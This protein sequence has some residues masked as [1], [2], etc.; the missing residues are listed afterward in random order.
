MAE[1]RKRGATAPYE[2]VSVT[3]EEGVLRRIRERTDN[4]SGFLND[5]A[6]DKLHFDGLREWA[7]ELLAQ[8]VKPDERFGRNLE[9][10]L[11]E[12]EARR[13]RKV[14]RRAG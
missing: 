12:V 6:A 9:A 5:A 3:L 7:N 10:W 11:D 13:A 14:R 8:G 1:R 2:K 4:V